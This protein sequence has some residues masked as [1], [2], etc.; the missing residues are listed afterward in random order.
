MGQYFTESHTE[1]EPS[2]PMDYSAGLRRFVKELFE[3]LLIAALLFAA[4]NGISSRIRVKSIS[5][6]PTLYEKDFVL[7]NKLAY[8]LGMPSRGDV[9]VFKYPLDP[10][11]EPY[12]K[13]I[14]GLPGDHIDING[15]TV[16]VNGEPLR[17]PYTKA[18]PNYIGSWDVPIG[19]LFVL[20]DN[21][22]NSSDSHQW[23]MVPIENV[24]GKALFVYYPVD[25][26]QLLNPITAA[27]A[28]P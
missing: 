4:I 19:S 17:E 3:T 27:A 2:P 1:P 11:S 28:G 10:E 13:R 12:I 7:V 24:L 15:G 14:I 5:M 25:H 23:G 22:N 21:R 20:G 8:Q 26:W 18:P 6:Q 16:I 9:I